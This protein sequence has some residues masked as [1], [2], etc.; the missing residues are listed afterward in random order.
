MEVSIDT[1]I[2]SE[3]FAEF[4]CPLDFQ[5]R[6]DYPASEP[7]RLRQGEGHNLI[8][9]SRHPAA[10]LAAHFVGR[11]GLPDAPCQAPRLPRPDQRSS[12]PVP[13]PPAHRFV[14]E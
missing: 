5:A 13:L 10:G 4:N 11:V 9:R 6:I 2:L 7:S 8:R 14:F 3:V 12:L 1:F